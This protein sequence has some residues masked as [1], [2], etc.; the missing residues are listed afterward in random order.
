[1]I[2]PQTLQNIL[3]L[4]ERVSVTG[5]EA[6]IW[7]DAYSAIRSELNPPAPVTGTDP[8]ANGWTEGPVV[9]PAQQVAADDT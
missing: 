5:T 1:M 8:A 7:C 9:T 6:V 2:H 3:K 4:L